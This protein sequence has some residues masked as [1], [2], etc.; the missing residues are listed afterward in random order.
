MRCKHTVS[1]ARSIQNMSPPRFREIDRSLKAV[2]DEIIYPVNVEIGDF[3]NFSGD[4]FQFRLRFVYNF[5]EYS[6]YEYVNRKDDDIQYY[7]AVDNK[8]KAVTRED[9]IGDQSELRTEVKKLAEEVAV[10]RELIRPAETKPRTLGMAQF[11]ELEGKT[12][13]ETS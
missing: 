4:Q 7:Q 1:I 2:D 13:K 9:I 12:I 5:I 10:L 8:L 11:N 3:S 6:F